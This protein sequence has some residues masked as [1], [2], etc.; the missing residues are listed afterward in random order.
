M[1]AAAIETQEPPRAPTKKEKAEKEKAEKAQAEPKKRGRKPKAKAEPKKGKA[2][3][4]LD[5]TEDPDY[6]PEL[7]GRR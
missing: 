2:R 4:P 1:R 5:G 3:V 7:S 6:D